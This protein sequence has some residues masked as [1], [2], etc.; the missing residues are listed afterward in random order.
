[1]H[2]YLY[3][4][5]CIIYIY[6]YPSIYLSIYLSIYFRCFSQPIEWKNS[7]ENPLYIKSK[8]N[9]I[10]TYIYIIYIYY[11]TY[12]YSKQQYVHIYT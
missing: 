10:Y 11:I 9:H 3:I 5:L 7:N 12:I 8:L 4:Y 6:I 1:M 2:I